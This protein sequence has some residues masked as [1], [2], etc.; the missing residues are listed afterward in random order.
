M[1]FCACII[2]YYVDLARFSS[3]P[4]LERSVVVRLV[5]TLPMLF[6][7]IVF[8]RSFALFPNKDEML[9]ANLTG[10]LV[11]A[12]LQSITF[13]TVFNALLLIVTAIYFLAFL[14]RS[15]AIACKGD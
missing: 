9:G 14:T 1:L 3:L 6:S 12:M 4:Y 7:G 11:G 8:I 15:D 13:V 2:L 5:T 10:S